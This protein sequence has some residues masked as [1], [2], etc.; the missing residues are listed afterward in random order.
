MPPLP[1]GCHAAAVRYHQDF[2]WPAT[3][4]GWAVWTLASEAID[5]LSI[6]LPLAGLV[7]ARLQERSRACPIVGVPGEPT[8]LVF[9]T[10]PARQVSNDLLAAFDHHD[11]LCLRQADRIELPPTRVPGGE[12]HWIELPEG[13]PA[14]FVAL[15]DAFLDA[16]ELY[17][18]IQSWASA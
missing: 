12:L 6:P 4:H 1:G 3:A 2:D 18:A 15:I 16:T 11:T 14:P 9:L 8:R 5:G 17:Q 13:T 7:Y 10:Q